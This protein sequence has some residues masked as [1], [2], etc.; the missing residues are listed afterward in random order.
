MIGQQYF[1]FL[2]SL[3]AP[4]PLHV[5]K[6]LPLLHLL[7]TASRSL[8]CLLIMEKYSEKPALLRALREIFINIGYER[9]ALRPED[10][11]HLGKRANFLQQFLGA[12]KVDREEILMSNRTS[13]QDILVIVLPDFADNASKK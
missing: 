3:M 11:E 1:G 7:S 4:P 12:L 8:F 10:A 2:S 9:I 13:V 5:L 6:A